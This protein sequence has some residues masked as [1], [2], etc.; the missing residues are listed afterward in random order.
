M[1]GQRKPYMPPGPVSSAF[2]GSRAFIEFVQGPLGSGKSTVCGAK[3]VLVTQWQN[4]SPVDRV[5]RAKIMVVRDTYRNLEKTTLPTWF[6]LVPK[7]VGHFTG[8]SGGVPA[9]HTIRWD[10][11][12]GGPAR[13][14]EMTMEFVGV[15]EHRAEDVFSSWEGTAVWINEANLVPEEVM[16]YA[17]QRPGRYPGADHGLC[18][19]WGV[20]AD[21]NAPS[22]TNWTYRWISRGQSGGLE[23]Q[24]RDAGVDLDALLKTHTK[25]FEYFRQPGWGEPGTE[26]LQHLPEN[27][28][29]L[30]AAIFTM[31]GQTHYITTKL[32]NQF[33]P[34]RSGKVVFPE[35][36][37]HRHVAPEA[38]APIPDTVLKIGAD[39]G[40]TPGAVITQEDPKG[41]ILAL[42]EL[43]PP[44][45]EVWGAK[46]FGE[47]LNRLLARKYRGWR[48][49]GWCDPAAGA[50][51]STDERSWVDVMRSVTGIAWRLAPT[52]GLLK[53]LEAVRAPLS[54]LIDGDV[55]FLLSPTCERL[56]EGFNSTYRFRKLQGSEEN[57]TEEPEKGPAS[58][59]QDALQYAMLGHGQHLEAEGRRGAA[60]GNSRPVQ[61]SVDWDPLA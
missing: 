58:H 43:A 8:G 30:Q 5:K 47:E 49:E 50:R 3:G 54:R 11:P 28:Y 51:S 61:A 36:A 25:V 33:G 23:K 38:L 44:S 10:F 4:P 18:N 2:Y 45:G 35:F 55:A 16:N 60:A 13:A 20:W 46:R 59:L 56:R 27:Y 41:R 12:E 14:A 39:A 17:L 26:N 1:S 34:D 42:D 31:N 53:R 15:G 24:L 22:V 6:K 19:W 29:A 7:D 48:C 21:F 32:K 37:D 9:V 40:L 57:Y 52:N